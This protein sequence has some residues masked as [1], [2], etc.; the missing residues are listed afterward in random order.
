MRPSLRQFPGRTNRQRAPVGSA[1]DH[2]SRDWVD[3]DTGVA[4]PFE[5]TLDLFIRTFQFQNDPAHIGSYVGA[6]DIGYYVKIAPETIYDR[7]SHHFGRKRE[8]YS[9]FRHGW[10]YTLAAARFSKASSN[11]PIIG[12]TSRGFTTSSTASWVL[13]PLPVM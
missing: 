8:P 2:V 4:Y 13:R 3:P 9:L 12:L 7:L 6:P 10:F 1:F 5:A 11:E